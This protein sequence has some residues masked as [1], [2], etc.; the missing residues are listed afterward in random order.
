MEAPRLERVAEDRLGS[1][2]GGGGDDGSV[3]EAFVPLSPRVLWLWRLQAGLVGLV[4]WAAFAVACALATAL[5]SGVRVAA[6][7]LAAAAV[8][9]LV[10][11]GTAAVYRGWRYAITDDGVELRHGVVIRHESSIP[12]FRVQH[13]DVEQGPLDRWRGIVKLQIS[14]ASSASDASLP[15]LEPERAEAVRA[16][17]LARAEA[18]DGV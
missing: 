3:G 16:R 17:I 8:V 11:T 5:P 7:V 10:A 6:V 15:G 1:T 12:H 4:L 2:T 9:G 18:D 14:T 13:I